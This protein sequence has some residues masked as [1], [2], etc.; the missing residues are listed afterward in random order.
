MKHI[1][2]IDDVATNL[3]CAA[4]VL[5][6]DYEVSTAKSGKQ[7]LLMLGELTP[8]LIM[9]D[10]NMP[11]MDGY[12][13]FAK[14]KENPEWA[15]IP[16]I[17][18]TAESDMA[19]EVKGLSMGAMDF[20]RKPFDPQVMKTRI[21]KVL[22]LNEQRL[23][24]EGSARR[25]SLTNLSTR[26]TFEEYLSSE[27]CENGY[28]LILDLDNFK[29]V[30]DSYGHVVGDAVLV[31]LASVFEEVVGNRDRVCRIGGDEFAIFIPGKIS[32]DEIRNT[33]RRLI[34]TSEFEIGNLIADYSDYK[35]SVSVGISCKPED[36]KSFQD[37]YSMADKALYFVKQNGK[38][39]Y[40]F[41][42]SEPVSKEDVD[43][44]DNMIDLMQL[45]RLI[46]ETETKD[47]P[48]NVE[49][50]GFK[51][52]YRFVA[53]CMDRKN[54]D[55]QIVLFTINGVDSNSLDKYN[56]IMK[57]LTGAV[58]NSLRRGDVATAFGKAQYV[59]ILLD[60]NEENGIKV[61][62]RIKEVFHD[63][64]SNKD[65]TLVYEMKSVEGA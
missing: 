21:D 54:Q 17:F 53:R 61:A 31:K 50:E 16:V 23:E 42:D 34:A 49:S 3:I 25:D 48:Y 4:E 47:G 10:I 1:L 59:V 64:V 44:E 52:I 63:A 2:M 22:S 28:F 39:G 24:T 29:K 30:N 27:E 18:L 5:R 19:K 33:I 35:V 36:S 58:S 57:T 14:L 46:S 40:H 62:D 12:E 65:I 6:E 11:Q 32:R 55:V 51:R 13:V 60:A 26:K 15:K 56:E 37:L 9:L 8:D 20:I 41:Y 7:A 43:A 45:Q 38:R